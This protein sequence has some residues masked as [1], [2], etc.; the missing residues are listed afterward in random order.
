MR[1]TS[2]GADEGGPPWGWDCGKWLH[3]RGFAEGSFGLWQAVA[4]KPVAGVFWQGGPGGYDRGDWWSAMEGVRHGL[5]SGIEKGRVWRPSF[6]VESGGFFFFG[7]Y[8]QD[9][10]S[11]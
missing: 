8:Y 3:P 1:S 11:S 6:A 9:T 5:A 4:T 10:K 7:P 2:L